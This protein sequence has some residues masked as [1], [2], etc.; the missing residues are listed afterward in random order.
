MGD[1]RQRIMALTAFLFLGLLATFPARCFSAANQPLQIKKE[2]PQTK[3]PNR[4][5]SSVVFPVQGNVYP[6][7]SYHV[8]INIGNPPKLY[9]L[10][11]DTGSDVTWVQCDAPCTGCTKP[12][13]RLYKPKA[14]NL[15]PCA[16]PACTAMNAPENPKCKD[17]KDQCDYEVNY[18]DH[19]SSFGVLVKDNFPVRLYNG[20][21]FSPQL[22]FG[23]GY[24]QKFSGSHPPPSTAGVLGLGNGKG[25][26]VSQ[27]HA[28]GLTQNVVGHCLSGRGGGFLFVGDDLVPSSGILWT[29][30]SHN[31]FEYH[32]SSGPAELL[33]GGKP[34]GVKG[35]LIVFDSGSSYTYFNAQAY[36]TTVNLL[37]KDLTGKPLK[38]APE[39]KSLPI[40]WKGPKSF[41]SVGHVKDYF[42]PLVLSFT[43]DRSVLLQLPPEAYLIVTKQGNVCLGI[44]NS[45]EVG[46]ENLNIIGDISMQ[47]KMVIYN[48]EKQLIGWTPANCDRHPKF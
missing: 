11:I 38:D 16:D 18:A 15:V 22:A 48:N 14:T 20:S 45:A 35:L 29:P 13:D 44:L 23:C 42:K 43:N 31:S 37:R 12:R 8:N 2:S 33:F 46:L 17:P 7:G 24:N 39:D 32:Y 26:V 40:C 30:I 41:K 36:Q 25:S 5:G 34:T 6:V 10:D 47:D 1:K 4:L 21:S 3:V 19:G 9:D 28:L 27:L